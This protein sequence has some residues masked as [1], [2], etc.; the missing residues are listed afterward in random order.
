MSVAFNTSINFHG[1]GQSH[2]K[3]LYLGNMVIY[4]LG[5]I[6]HV[7]STL[8]GS[9]ARF[10]DVWISA[11]KRSPDWLKVVEQSPTQSPCLGCVDK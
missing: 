1:N 6:L 8:S 9:W 10:V 7:E 5:Y 2:D 11:F 4:T 3:A